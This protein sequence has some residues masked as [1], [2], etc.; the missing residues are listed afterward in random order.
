MIDINLSHNRIEVEKSCQSDLTGVTVY[1]RPKRKIENELVIF[2]LKFDT[3][4]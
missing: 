1:V 2:V 3:Q 4:T